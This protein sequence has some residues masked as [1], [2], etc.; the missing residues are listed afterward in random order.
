MADETVRKRPRI[1]RKEI[2]DR[3]VENH[4]N[5]LM[6][7]REQIVSLSRQLHAE[8]QSRCSTCG[9]KEKNDS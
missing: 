4:D 6:F 1:P 5:H 3:L 8:R 7:L 9:G 2:W